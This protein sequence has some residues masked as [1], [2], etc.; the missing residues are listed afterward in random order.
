MAHPYY[1]AKADVKEHVLVKIN[2]EH[3]VMT[4]SDW[5]D[6]QNGE[7]IETSDDYNHLMKEAEKRNAYNEFVDNYSEFYQD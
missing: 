2:S 7:V 4:Y 6:W 1:K 5:E 3:I